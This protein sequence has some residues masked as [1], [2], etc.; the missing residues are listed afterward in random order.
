[1]TQR[2]IDSDNI[3]NSYEG[4]PDK[5]RAEIGSYYASM[6]N[7]VTGEIKLGRKTHYSSDKI[8]THEIIEL[9]ANN[10]LLIP[11]KQAKIRITGK[12][13]KFRDF[14][15]WESYVRET[16]VEG[17]QY[18][19]H[20][21]SMQTF[22]VEKSFTK[23]ERALSYEDLSKTFPS[24]QLLNYNLITYPYED[25]LI[26]RIGYLKTVFGN[27]TPSTTEVSTLINQFQNRIVNYSSSIGEVSLKQRNIFNLYNDA[28]TKQKED[29]PFFYR[30]KI[31]AQQQEGETSLVDTLIEREKLK[32]IFQ[33]IKR[34]LSFSNRSFFVEGQTIQGKI[35]NAIEMMTT[36]SINS[37][38]EGTDEIF[39]LSEN[40]TSAN[41]M[42]RR[43]TDQINTVKF[44][45]SF[46]SQIS[47]KSR[48]IGEIF[49]SR[50]C[51]TFL[52]GYKIEKYLD[53]DANQPLQT[54]Y[55]I[56]DNLVD[57]QIKYGRKYIYKTKALVGIYGSSYSYSNLDIFEFNDDYSATVDVR[58]TPSLQIL[59]YAID[60]HEI[61]HLD[62][63]PIVPNVQSYGNMK[64]SVVNFLLTP[65]GPSKY[66]DGIYDIYR[67][68]YPPT[69]KRQM[70]EGLIYS[71]DQTLTVHRKDVYT[72]EVDLKRAEFEDQL[73]SNK[74]YYYAFKAVS[75]HG[76]KS[77]LSH[78]L[79]VEAQKD[80]DE[81]KLSVK[82]YDYPKM[83]EHSY[84]STAKRLL[85]ISPNIERLIFSK[86]NGSN[87]ELDEGSL[88]SSD[89]TGKSF[90][91]RVTSKHTGKK[92]DINL[93]F[94]LNKDDTFN[95]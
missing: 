87:F 25:E 1:M 53:N 20:S 80:S 78:V 40:E 89:G 72:K 65:G 61:V 86:E 81:F 15:Q 5:L 30:E 82:K 41:K 58:A 42:G 66:N 12:S 91:I 34:D 31:V 36:T 24:N 74:K 95:T 62:Q 85:H 3:V 14:T 63:E 75:Y 7:L 43:F 39:L 79:E 88:V 60:E 94:K 11:T 13:T 9:P 6:T 59:E 77:E 22:E 48:N 50:F 45:S 16:I 54:Y 23:N 70:E 44:L 68:E 64:K 8:S 67:L 90:K 46:R 32:N 92:L 57:T 4:S 71:V 49:D 10:Q 2:I 17:E 33:S 35:Y 69:S 84:S 28:G 76:I 37:F 52:L 19:D 38:S 51:K 21:F 56:H 29:F 27:F 26:N 83:E 93:R 55:T 18:L 73:I 47:E